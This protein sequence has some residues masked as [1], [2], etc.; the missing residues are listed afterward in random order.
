MYLLFT[1]YVLVT[2]KKNGSQ[3]AT[4]FKS[5]FIFCSRSFPKQKEKKNQINIRHH[6]EHHRDGQL[7]GIQV[8]SICKT[9]F[10]HKREEAPGYF[11]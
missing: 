7:R 9:F 4:S 2:N 6:G 3:T 8:I 11:Q 1:N 5:N 10:H